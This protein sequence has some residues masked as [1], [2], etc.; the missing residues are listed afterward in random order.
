MNT[1]TVYVADGIGSYYHIRDII[2]D[3]RIFAM[4]RRSQ[5]IYTGWNITAH[6]PLPEYVH[7]CG[8]CQDELKRRIAAV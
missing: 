4:C 7:L 8:E 5:S 6:G 3:Y 2:M 1:K